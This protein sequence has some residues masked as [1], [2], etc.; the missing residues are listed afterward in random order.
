[1]LAARP[2]RVDRRD[3]QTPV[4]GR[5]R[6]Q[7]QHQLQRIERTAQVH[8]RRHRTEVGRDGAQRRL[9]HRQIDR[10]VVAV[11]GG[12]LPRVAHRGGKRPHRG[13][14][15]LLD[16]GHRADGRGLLAVVGHGGMR[17]RRESGRE[18]IERGRIATRLDHA[19]GQPGHQP[20]GA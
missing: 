3:L 4:A 2:I 12:Q 10:L 11:G 20:P 18:A 8:H 7:L 15:E 17:Q 1:M 6:G 13:A 16:G 14:H 9:Q 19:L 5:I